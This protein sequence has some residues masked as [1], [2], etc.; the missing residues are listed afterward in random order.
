MYFWW[1]G[2]WHQGFRNLAA[3]SFVDYACVSS[4]SQSPSPTLFD[5]FRVDLKTACPMVWYD[6]SLREQVAGEIWRCRGTGVSC[7]AEME[8]I[9]PRWES[10]LSF[11]H[12]FRSH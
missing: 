1:V 3:G 11:T 4:P 10:S 8:E 9:G 12:F 6:Y 7:G 5:E 2:S